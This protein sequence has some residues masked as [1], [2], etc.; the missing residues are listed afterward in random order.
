MSSPLYWSYNM[1]WNYVCSYSNLATV[2]KSEIKWTN[3]RMSS[4]SKIAWWFAISNVRQF[5]VIS[6]LNKSACERNKWNKC[7]IWIIMPMIL[8]KMIS[9]RVIIFHYFVWN[10]SKNIAKRIFA[11]NDDFVGEFDK[12]GLNHLSTIPSFC[13][14]PFEWHFITHEN[15]IA[16]V[17]SWNFQLIPSWTQS[18]VPKLS[19][20][21]SFS[22]ISIES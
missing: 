19:L 20:S 14:Q 6:S 2:F 17:S 8:V 16:L 22:A 21:L 15:R 7:H 1:W 12:R 10:W 11:R 13:N 5:E 18:S 9:H 4:K 3:R